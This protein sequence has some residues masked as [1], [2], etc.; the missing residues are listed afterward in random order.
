MTQFN[1]LSHMM[2][3][4]ITFLYNYCTVDQVSRKNGL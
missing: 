4:N 3:L 1:L 2:Q